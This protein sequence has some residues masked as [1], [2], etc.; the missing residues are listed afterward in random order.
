MI[1]DQ[2]MQKANRITVLRA[3]KE[4]QMRK[5]APQQT[6]KQMQQQE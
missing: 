6:Q 5:Q 3:K 4:Y 1:E 2:N